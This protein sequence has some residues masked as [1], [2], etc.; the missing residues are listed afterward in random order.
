MD[1]IE[2]DSL[3]SYAFHKNLESVAESGL[4]SPTQCNSSGI[5]DTFSSKSENS[6]TYGSQVRYIF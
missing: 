1:S 5:N 3:A 4:P 2:P 6:I